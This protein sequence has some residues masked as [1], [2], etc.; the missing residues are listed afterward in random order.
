MADARV[1]ARRRRRCRRRC[2]RRAFRGSGLTRTRSHVPGGGVLEGRYKNPVTTSLFNTKLYTPSSPLL[3]RNEKPAMATYDPASGKLSIGRWKESLPIHVAGATVFLSALF[4]LYQVTKYVPDPY[5]DEVFHVPQAQVYCRGDYQTWDNKITTPAGLYAFSN[6]IL[7]LTGRCSTYDLRLTNVLAL[8]MLFIFAATC[9]NIIESI[10]SN[11][12]SK[13]PLKS[14]SFKLDRISPYALHTAFNITLFPPVFFFS[15]LYYT[16]ILST[17]VVILTYCVFLRREG[18][19]NNS[20]AGGILVFVYGILALTM[21]QTNIFWVAVFLGGLEVVRT[22]KS[23]GPFTARTWKGDLHPYQHFQNQLEA[24][25]RGEVHDVTLGDATLFYDCPLTAISI[26]IAAICN[27][28]LIVSRLWPC[29]ALLCLFASFVIWNGGVVLG[30]KSNH[31]ATIHLPQLLYIWPFFV[32]FSAP[33]LYPSALNLLQS[34]LAPLFPRLHHEQTPNP[35]QAKE[36]RNQQPSVGNHSS[37]Q[38]ITLSILTQTTLLLITLPIIHYNTIIHPFTLADN[39]HYVFYVFRYS[40]RAHPLI[41][42]LLSPIYLFCGWLVLRG[43]SSAVTQTQTIPPSPTSPPKNIQPQTPK[44]PQKQGAK[45][46]PTNPT[47]T[48]IT[49]TATTSFTIIWSLSTALSLIS[50]PLVE[51][52]YFIIPWVIWRLHVP[53][54]SSSVVRR[55]YDHRLWLET[56]WFLGINAVTGYVFL[57]RGFEWVQEGGRVQRFMW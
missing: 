5:L 15:A 37:N 35:N 6:I 27:S 56:L 7:K 43:L 13:T 19:Y 12:T 28:R 38:N 39:R 18:A 57:F 48:T 44:S 4:W 16:D 40:I 50:A 34:L 30:D 17:A 41:K 53:S 9:R 11:T 26:A 52:R 1:V 32:F 8:F 33:L 29:I 22:V 49:T 42:Y 36:A 54:T 10:P 51:P 25:A 3:P 14:W 20:S 47:T 55:G 24:Y 2:R 45:A 31:V 21:R 23:L 46:E